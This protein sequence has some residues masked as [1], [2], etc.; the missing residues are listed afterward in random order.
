MTQRPGFRSRGQPPLPLIQMREQH[1]ELRGQR[2]LHL[3][4]NAHTT[5][6]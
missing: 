4:R 3:H 1:P 2:L 5:G 6:T